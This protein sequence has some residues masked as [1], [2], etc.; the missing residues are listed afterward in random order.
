M[1]AVW[2]QDGEGSEIILQVCL[3]R[4]LSKLCVLCVSVCVCYH[5]AVYCAADQSQD[6]TPMKQAED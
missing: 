4:L 6:D 1:D 2:K 3:I 5:P